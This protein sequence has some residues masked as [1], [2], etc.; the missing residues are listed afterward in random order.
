MIILVSTYTQC[1]ITDKKLPNYGK[2]QWQFK[3]TGPILNSTWS[4]RQAARIKDPMQEMNPARN[5]LKGKV[6]TRQQ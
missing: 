5:A 6:P 1:Q 4:L 2:I 3:F